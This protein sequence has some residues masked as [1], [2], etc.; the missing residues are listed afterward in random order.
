MSEFDAIASE[1]YRQFVG[2]EK[3][4]DFLGGWPRFHDAEILFFSL[5][6]RGSD[7]T[8]G[9]GAVMRLHTFEWG[10]EAD[11]GRTI[12]HRHCTVEF[13]FTQVE[14]LHLADFN[15]Q[16]VISDL[17]FNVDTREEPRRWMVAFPAEHGLDGQ[18]S[19]ETVEVVAV[20]PGIPPGSIY[21]K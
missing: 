9:P 4:T 2:Y 11:S 20:T 21:E 8:A 6:R 7:P 17:R 15:F 1:L 10:Q 19:C 16:N 18:F 13:R 5:E 3:L 14:D 12:F